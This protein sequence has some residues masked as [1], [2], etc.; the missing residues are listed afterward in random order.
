V[1]RRLVSMSRGPDGID[2]REY[3]SAWA[4][5]RRAVEAAG[6]NAWRFRSAAA[7]DLYIEFLEFRDGADPRRDPEVAKA[8][9]ALD[10]RFPGRVE[11]WV[12]ATVSAEE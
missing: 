10:R 1:E 12:D 7:G 3:R 6:G 5:L 8:L 11:E 4:A 2:G 9:E